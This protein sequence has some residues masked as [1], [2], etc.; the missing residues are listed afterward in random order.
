MPPICFLT[1]ATGFV[2]RNLAPL[3]ARRYRLRCLLRPGTPADALDPLP[4]DPVPGHLG[5]EAAL[6]TGCAGADLVVHLAAL[7][8]FRREDRAA[9]FAINVDATATLA[10]IARE[11]AVRRFLHCS[12]ISAIGYSDTP[13]ELDENTPFNYGPLRIGYCD[14][15][16]A[17]E[18]V[19]RNEA[20]RGLDAVIVNPPSM[21]GTGDRRKS[22][23][24]LL[25][26][27]L[28]GRIRLA[29]PG[30]LNVADVLSVCE[31]ML[32]AI[33]RGRRGERYILGGE[34]LHGR[35]LLARIA[36]AIGGT[37]PR[38]AVPAWLVRTAS[39]TLGMKERLLGS[40]RGPVTSEILALAPRFLWMSSRKAVQELGFR[41]SS[42]DPGIRAAALAAGITA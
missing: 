3:L 6:R 24:S 1:G 4:F 25:D 32:L 37:A 22:E 21:Y 29:P 36:S 42:V 11:S 12:T 31:G 34:N 15:K 30:G 40:G 26:A 35:E 38:R 27:V 9:M 20:S 39:A 23:G 17:A 5:D 33:E 14:S 10:R 28:R 8:S 7:V 18:Q 41:P 13:R 16:H 2:G 19:V